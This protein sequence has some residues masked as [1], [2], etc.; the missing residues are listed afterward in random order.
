MAFG[1]NPSSMSQ[2]PP[3]AELQWPAADAEILRTL[4]PVLRA[5][6]AALGFARAQ[7]WLSARGGLNVTIPKAKSAGIDLEPEEL[8]RLRLTLA[9][10]M[11][12]AGR[13]WLPKPD[14]LFKRVRDMQIRRNRPTMSIAE[15]A[16]A[17]HLSSRHI[18]NIT[19]E[20]GDS[21][22]QLTLF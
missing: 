17:N 6:V 16:R 3:A 19:R 12:A 15:L 11:D 20:G 14:K 9:P 5:V 4:P 1:I 10:H 13:V 2:Q 21:D 22:E 7:T 8:T 18:V